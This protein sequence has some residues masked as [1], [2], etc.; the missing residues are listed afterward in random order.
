M[1]RA[2]ALDPRSFTSTR[3]ERCGRFSA[4][5]AAE[6]EL[7][8][9]LK[10]HNAVVADDK[11]LPGRPAQGAPAEVQKFPTSY[12]P[13]GPCI[14][15]SGDV[16]HDGDADLF[17][18]RFGKEAHTAND[19]LMYRTISPGEVDSDHDG[20]S[21]D[22]EVK[23]G[24]D[25]YNPETAGDG[26]LDGWKGERLQGFGHEGSRVQSAPSRHHRFDFPL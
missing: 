16:D 7:G 22:E 9:V 2:L 1:R 19:V 25:P 26:L 15:A 17:Q 20:L 12:L 21:N 23:L 11:G 5:G 6:R 4:A 14:W 10:G 18:F 13:P 24:S 8:K 3:A